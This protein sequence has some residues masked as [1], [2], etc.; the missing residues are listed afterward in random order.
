MIKQTFCELIENYES[1]LDELGLGYCIRMESLI[2]AGKVVKYHERKN[3]NTVSDE[4]TASYLQEM[5][6][7]LY[8]GTVSKH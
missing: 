6:D 5:A 1:V 3:L 7:G 4:I 2:F 8:D